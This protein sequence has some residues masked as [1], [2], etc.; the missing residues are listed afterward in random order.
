MSG[1]SARDTRLVLA[2]EPRVQLLPRFVQEREKARVARRMIVL[3]VILVVVAVGGATFAAYLK[4]TLAQ[5]ELAAANQ[6]TQDLLE[7]QKKYAPGAVAAANLADLEQAI[8]LAGA[9]DVLWADLTHQIADS[10]P[11][12]STM[13]EVTWTTREPWGAPLLPEGALRSPR[14][15]T[16]QF[17]LSSVSIPDA[18]TVRDQLKANVTGYADSYIYQSQL[19]DGV[20][21]T[22][23]QV[24]LDADA[25][26]HRF[27][28]EKISAAEE[29]ATDLAELLKTPEKERTPEQAAAAAQLVAQY[30]L[31]FHRDPT[32]AASSEPT[33]ESTDASTDDEGD[34][35]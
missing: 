16:V 33:D 32:P 13:V 34:A 14:E 3:L 35:Q 18:V 5:S 11:P 10:R 17:V 26:S 28:A 22:R 29:G 27:S 30:A 31:G 4:S 6:T 23:I 8:G 7:Q 19:K 21:L 20:Y 15:A 9:T 12:G 2:G 1:A 25:L 24:T